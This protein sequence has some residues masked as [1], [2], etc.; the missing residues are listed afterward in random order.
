MSR[1]ASK[2][3]NRRR[4]KDTRKSHESQTSSSGRSLSEFQT[5]VGTGPLRTSVILGGANLG[6][7][8]MN[9]T[10]LSASITTIPAVIV[11]LIVPLAA[12]APARP[13]PRPSSY[14]SYASFAILRDFPHSK[15]EPCLVGFGSCASMYSPPTACLA[16]TQRCRG[17]YRIELAN[18][19]T[20]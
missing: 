11:M 3:I 5:V 20:R 18:A 13:P 16:S 14:N 19:E 7:L 2:S 8:T 17:D 12:H 1:P 15:V 10:S 4:D 6:L 9:A